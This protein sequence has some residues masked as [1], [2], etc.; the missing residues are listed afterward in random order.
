MLLNQLL[1]EDLANAA[2]IKKYLKDKFNL[3]N[4][5]LTD[6]GIDTDDYVILTSFDP[7]ESLQYKFHRVNGTFDI[8]TEHLLD[9]DN[10]PTIVETLKIDRYAA[11]TL[12]GLSDE[13]KDVNTLIITSC[14][15]ITDLRGCPTPKKKLMLSNNKYL[16]SFDGLNLQGSSID[17]I[18][19]K[20]CPIEDF[21]A[22]PLEGNISVNMSLAVLSYRFPIVRPCLTHGIKGFNQIIIPDEI[23]NGLKRVITPFMG[24]GLGNIPKL[25]EAL[26]NNGYERHATFN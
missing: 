25:I 10:F 9:F 18:I 8:V 1:S 22:I 6:L 12:D 13:V 19:E 3:V 2:Q 4:Y 7:I 24:T 23:P 5:K 16:T 15:A 14:P 21:S 26:Y 17:I 20:H 11:D